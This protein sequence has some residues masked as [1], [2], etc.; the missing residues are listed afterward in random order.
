MASSRV[1]TLSCDSSSLTLWAQDSLAP[2]QTV[3]LVDVVVVVEVVETEDAA[4]DDG[5]R[6]IGKQAATPAV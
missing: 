5:L 4:D 3:L 6:P 1:T 2:L